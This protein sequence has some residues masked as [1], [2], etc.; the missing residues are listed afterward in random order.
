MAFYKILSMALDEKTHFYLEN[1]K[2]YKK[3]TPQ[4][5]MNRKTFLMVW[6]LLI[7]L[8]FKIFFVAEKNTTIQ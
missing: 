1:T 6:I 8:P 2:C 7:S 5:K 3:D 4:R